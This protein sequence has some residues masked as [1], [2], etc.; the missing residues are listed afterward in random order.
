MGRILG[1]IGGVGP[2]QVHKAFSKN[3]KGNWSVQALLVVTLAA[4]LKRI[5]KTLTRVENNQDILS[6]LC[7]PKN[8]VP[9]DNL[10]CL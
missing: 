4:G 10:S 9:L 2:P 5:A 3:L 8:G 1:V 6:F 7:V